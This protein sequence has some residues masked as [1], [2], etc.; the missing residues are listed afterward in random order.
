VLW[1]LIGTA[2]V[3]LLAAGGSYAWFQYEV[4]GANS[5]VDPGVKTV[6]DQKVG[7]NLAVDYGSPSAMN[8][9]VVG[10]D[11]RPT[12][13]DPSSR[14]DTMMIVHVDPNSNYLSVLS[15]PR[16]MWVSIPGHGKNR[17]NTAYAYGGAKLT[18]QTLHNL[19]V[20]A[21]KYVE[22]SF[23]AFQDITDALGGVYVDVD[24]RY[25]NVTTKETNYEPINLQP[26]Y[27][28]LNGPQALGYV[29]FRHDLTSDIGRMRRQQRFLSAVREQVG[30]GSALKLP[31]VISALFSNVGTTLSADEIL[32]L[33][34]WAAKLDGNRIRQ[35][36]VDNVESDQTLATAVN[37]LLT[38]SS[39]ASSSSTPG[40]TATTGSKVQ[41]SG[42]SIDIIDKSGQ[43]GLLSGAKQW[44]TALGATVVKTTQGSTTGLKTTKV[45]YP[46]GSKSLAQALANA[47]G[48]QSVVLDSS[49]DR[50][51]LVLGDD[52][53]VPSQYGPQ[54][55]VD[56]ILSKDVWYGRAKYA[57]FTVEA[58]T[59]LP[60][61]Y[62]YLSTYPDSYGTYNI[63]VG[64]GTKPAFKVIYVSKN[65][66]LKK[67]VP[68]DYLGIAETTWLD[69]PLASK[70]IYTRENNGVTYNVVGT[71]RQVDHIWWKKDGVLYW[72][73]NTLQY[74]VSASDLLKIAE[75]MVALPK[76]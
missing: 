76:S 72:V 32:K 27:Q 23:Q 24:H 65:V 73:S 9:L 43:S 12:S 55:S 52:L 8:I 3:V 36:T 61:E 15:L 40:A 6:L 21:N 4:A 67:V 46:S 22:V 74:R 28:R 16:D 66:D 64:N 56:N 71:Y 39:A 60:S 70:P 2:L 29:R 75:N 68:S 49:V 30:W 35:V 69:A 26:G 62:K 31:G 10:Y 14:S 44:M 7:G 47:V 33:A 59:W 11:K 17:L 53:A 25:Y 34:S 54:P 63:K 20:P 50:V 41:L 51:T 19:G 57:G 48:S 37:Q 45:A 42:D 1:T 5:R 13:Q 18:I 38:P 58:P